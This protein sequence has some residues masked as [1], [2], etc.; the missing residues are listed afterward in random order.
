MKTREEAME[1]LINGAFRL[2]LNLND[3]FFWACADAEEIDAEDSLDLVKYI[4]KYDYFAIEAF[5]SA[6]RELLQE[7]IMHPMLMQDNYKK[8]FGD[9]VLEKR[10]LYIQARAE[11]M[12]AIISGTEFGD[13]GY[14]YKKIKDDE[15]EFGERVKWK[16]VQLEGQKYYTQIAYLSKMG[17]SGT[18]FSMNDARA[19]LRREYDRLKSEKEKK[20]EK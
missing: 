18:G 5:V 17:I 11:I 2:S 3:T 16:S 15:Q 1:M 6:K 4:Q 7:G 9:D 14:E 13:V 12:Q 10:K 19:N 20:N 8:Y